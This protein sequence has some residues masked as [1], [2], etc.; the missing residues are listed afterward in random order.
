MRAFFFKRRVGLVGGIKDGGSAGAKANDTYPSAVGRV[1]VHDDIG[2]AIL[3]S[4]PFD[5]AM[6]KTCI[7]KLREQ[8]MGKK[9]GE[10]EGRRTRF[11][12]YAHA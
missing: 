7:P 5:L 1:V 11:R 4:I 12:T 9:G 10:G 2:P 6:I 8:E 3:A